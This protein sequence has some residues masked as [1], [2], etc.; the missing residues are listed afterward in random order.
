MQITMHPTLSISAR[1][2]NTFLALNFTGWPI[3]QVSGMFAGAK[4][5][6]LVQGASGHTSGGLGEAAGEQSA[7]QVFF[8][9]NSWVSDT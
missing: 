9:V 4:L 7:V 6:L 2:S 3:P 1:Q 5:N 8:A